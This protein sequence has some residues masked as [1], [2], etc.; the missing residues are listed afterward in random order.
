MKTKYAVSGKQSEEHI[1]KRIESRRRN[2]KTYM[3]IGY[4]VW[5]KGKTKETDERVEKYAKVHR[6]GRK[7]SIAGYVLI[8]KP[9]HPSVD[10]SGYVYEHTVVM[11]EY[12]KRPLYKHE[13]IHHKD[14]NKQNNNINNLMILTNSEHAKLHWE[15]K[16]KGQEGI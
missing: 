6:L 8:Y 14:K 16:K 9:E 15:E 5:N 12:L 13:T 3:P 11:E 4:V 7:L 10:R 2:N 1:R